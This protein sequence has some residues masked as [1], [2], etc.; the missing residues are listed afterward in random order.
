ML[1]TS[2]VF[3]LFLAG[4]I[5]CAT[6]RE[7]QVVADT[8]S[9]AEAG[10]H[11]E[12]V[13]ET[14]S[15]EIVLELFPED[16]PVTVENFLAYVRGGFY[17]GLIFH[18]VISGFMI[19]AGSLTGNMET[20]ST[21]R[22]PIANEAENGLKNIRGKL[23]MARTGDPHSATSEFFINHADNVVLD[24]TNRTPRGWGYA[25]FGQVV[26]GMAVVDSI[27]AASTQ[28]RGRR[29]DFPV[30]PIVINRAYVR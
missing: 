22:F 25:V 14:S 28:R 3:V 15:G 26:S 19:Q 2:I 18:R 4:A 7:E 8:A 9:V 23:A 20:R 24:F 16:A 30:D 1:K 13:L 21:S 10:P 5:S 27:A 17:N 12:V 6:Q 11:P 29:A